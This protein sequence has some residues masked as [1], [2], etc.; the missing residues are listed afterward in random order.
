VHTEIGEWGK[1]LNLGVLVVDKPIFGIS[2]C[3][4]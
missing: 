3:D 1:A 2:I 4:F